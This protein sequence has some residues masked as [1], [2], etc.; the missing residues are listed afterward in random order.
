MQDIEKESKKGREEFS[1]IADDESNKRVQQVA[2]KENQR[3]MQDMRS[4]GTIKMCPS[5]LEEIPAIQSH[6]RKQGKERKQGNGNMIMMCC[7]VV[8]CHKCRDKSLDFMRGTSR[9]DPTTNTRCY[10]CRE[11]VYDATYWANNIKPYDKRHWLLQGV[12]TEYMNGTGE[13]KQDI[14]KAMKLYKRAAAELGNT[15]AQDALASSYFNGYRTTRCFEK[16]RYYAEKAAPQG[17]VNSQYILAVL[18][19]AEDCSR[20]EEAFQLLTLAA[21]QGS[22]QARFDLGSIYEKK[23]VGNEEEWRKNLLLSLYW[24]G[25]SAEVLDM[26]NSPKGYEKLPKVVLHLDKFLTLLLHPNR[27]TLAE[28]SDLPFYDWAISKG[29]QHSESIFPEHPLNWLKYVCANCGEES[30]NNKQLKNCA[31]CAVFH[32]CSKKCQA[33]NWKAGHKVDCK[34][35]WLKTFFPKSWP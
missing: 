28:N 24:Y 14:K 3:I 32:Y 11:P 15:E 29:G 17:A 7:S 33:E 18:L 22:A 13:L 35:E 31:R 27:A 5:C 16:A 23:S 2:D 4:K 20:D 26:K 30:Q 12:A 9:N 8:H 34:G 1:R 25:K 19:K 10:N 21:F 6:E